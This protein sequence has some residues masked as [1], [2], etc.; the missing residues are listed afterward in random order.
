[1]NS[2]NRARGTP[3][4]FKVEA[5]EANDQEKTPTGRHLQQEPDEETSSIVIGNA[6]SDTPID[7]SPDQ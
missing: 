7:E 6:L 1:M 3:P 5:P 4:K 2:A